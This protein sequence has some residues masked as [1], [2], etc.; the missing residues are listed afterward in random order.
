MCARSSAWRLIERPMPLSRGVLPMPSAYP[1]LKAVI[2]AS[3]V[4]NLRRRVPRLRWTSTATHA[5][6]SPCQ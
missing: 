3:G 6:S 5:I 4:S 2:C 1:F